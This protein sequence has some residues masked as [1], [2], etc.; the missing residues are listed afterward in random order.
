MRFKYCVVVLLFAAVIGLI[1]LASPATAA[2]GDD[3]VSV[4][5]PGGYVVTFVKQNPLII[6]PMTV[7]D[8]IGQGEYKWQSKN[9]NYYTEALP[10]NLYWGVPSNSLRL[11]IF[12]PDGAV[13]GP[14]YDDSDGAHNGNICVTITRSGGVAQGTWYTEVYGDAVSGSQSYSI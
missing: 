4:T 9:V 12:T 7:Y 10:F 5:G 6:R 2:K 13:L 8:T 11:R 3:S 1:A 14:Y